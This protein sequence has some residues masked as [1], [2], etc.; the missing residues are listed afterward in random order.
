[1]S[2][3]EIS[4]EGMIDSVIADM[5]PEIAGAFRS[6]M[7]QTYRLGGAVMRRQMMEAALQG[8]EAMAEAMSSVRL[9]GI[10]DH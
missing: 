8:Q 1:M 5:D 3:G 9:E 7:I 4:L 2:I 6:A 10:R